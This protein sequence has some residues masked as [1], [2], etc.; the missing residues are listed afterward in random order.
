MLTVML[1]VFVFRF[2]FSFSLSDGV[3]AFHDLHATSGSAGQLGFLRSALSHFITEQW[4]PVKLAACV[5]VFV[6]I[7]RHIHA[8]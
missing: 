2:N 3:I 4:R 6:L 8:M 1:C 7:P 5:R